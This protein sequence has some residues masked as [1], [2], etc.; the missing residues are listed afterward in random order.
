MNPLQTHLTTIS[1]NNEWIQI[2]KMTKFDGSKTQ[3][4]IINKL[5]NDILTMFEG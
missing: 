4:Q 5:I 2:L 3:W 1:P